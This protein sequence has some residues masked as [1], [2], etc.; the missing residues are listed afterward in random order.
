MRVS[1]RSPDSLL[2]ACVLPYPSLWLALYI[3]LTIIF[4]YWWDIRNLRVLHLWSRLRIQ[5]Y[6]GYG[7]VCLALGIQILSVL[8]TNARR[9][10]N[11][12]SRPKSVV[13]R[14]VR[15]LSDKEKNQGLKSWIL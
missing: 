11:L 1:T 5:R 14:I 8:H 10:Y 15:V 13:R 3:P 6:Q 12:N 9:E 4:E 2:S 7:H